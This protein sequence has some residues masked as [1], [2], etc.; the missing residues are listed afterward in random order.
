MPDGLTALVLAG[1]RPGGDPLA[2]FA[3]VSHKALIDIHGLAMIERVILAL[4]ASTRVQRIVVSIDRPE[5]VAGL[6]ALQQVAA[7]GKTLATRCAA[8][9]PSASVAEALLAE[10][11]PLLVVTGDHPLLRPEWIETLVAASPDWA[12]AV[13]AL[14]PR[15]AVLEA[16]PD[17]RR[18]WLGFA[19]GAFSGCNLF[20]LRRPAARGVVEL[21]QRVEQARKRPL[22]MILFLGIGF[23]LRYLSGRLSLDAALL[24][25][26]RLSGARVGWVALDDGRAAIDVDKPDDLEKVRRL[27]AE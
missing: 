25:L 24:R 1:A 23:G 26:G 11:T 7:H 3:G 15:A 6:P 5:I 17:T 10:G 20:L 14:A 13:V 4:T 2:D 16:V 12:D 19:E 27:L 18:T 21:W 22:R 8:S 9:G